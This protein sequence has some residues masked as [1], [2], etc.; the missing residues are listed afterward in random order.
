MTDAD[1]SCLS[2]IA[3][4]A[5]TM[6]SDAYARSESVL[7]YALIVTFTVAPFVRSLR[8][9]FHGQNVVDA[10]LLACHRH[11]EWRSAPFPSAGIG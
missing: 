1:V 7:G 9:H 11:L 4:I 8:R 6:Q 10:D 3:H 5:C 2:K